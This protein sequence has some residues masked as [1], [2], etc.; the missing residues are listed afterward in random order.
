MIYLTGSWRA[1]PPLPVDLSRSRSSLL[2]LISSC[3]S[4][5]A[6][7]FG[8]GGSAFGGSLLI[9]SEAGGH[10]RLRRCILIVVFPPTWVGHGSPFDS[11]AGWHASC[12]SEDCICL[13]RLAAQNGAVD[14]NHW[15][16]DIFH[17][18]QERQHQ[19]YPGLV[20]QS[21]LRSC[22]SDP[23]TV[24]FSSHQHLSGLYL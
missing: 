17:T 8:G 18:S 3:P 15:I 20:G 13:G 19:N 23:E 14:H 10:Q 6:T 16:Q 22:P 9:G 24:P 2:H 7:C 21:C 5:K 4:A 1:S 12:C 11:A